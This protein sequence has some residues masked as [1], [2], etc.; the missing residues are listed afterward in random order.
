MRILLLVLITPLFLQAQLVLPPVR[1]DDSTASGF[2][3]PLFEP[4]ADGNLICTW[5][6]QGLVH[7]GA[8]GQEVMLNGML[9]GPRL[10]FDE[11]GS[12]TMACP[13]RLSFVH[14]HDGGGAHLIYH[15]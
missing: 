3:Y 12:D 10:T 8:Y 15:S 11:L 2:Y 5:A 4:H 14:V 9:M 1:L 6:Q 7:I 13:P